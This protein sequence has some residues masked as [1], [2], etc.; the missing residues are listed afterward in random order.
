[1]LADLDIQFYEPYRQIADFSRGIEWPA[2]C[3]GGS[4]NIVHNC[5][6][7][8]LAAGSGERT[9]LRWE[10]EEGASRSSDLRRT[11]ARK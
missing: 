2:W 10:G 4:M 1:M 7:K 9:A 3:V 11:G 6:D 8:W 5:L